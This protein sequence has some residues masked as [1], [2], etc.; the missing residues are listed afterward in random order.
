MAV[1]LQREAGDVCGPRS[2]LFRDAAARAAAWLAAHRWAVLTLN[3][4]VG[5]LY[6]PTL[7]YGFL[8]WDDP[9]YILDNP[10]IRS[11]HPA[12]LVRIIT[13]V[14][15]RN[16]AP[17]T[18]FSF[19]VDHTLWDAWAGGYHL[20]NFVLHGLNGVLLY[21]LI[22]RLSGSRSV[23]W[24]T[25]ALWAVHPVQVESVAWISSRKGVLSATFLLASSLCWLREERNERHEFQGMLWF[26]LALLTK[27]IAVVFPAVVLSYDL[28]VRRKPLSDALARQIIPGFLAL[29]LLVTTVGAQNAMLGGVREHLALSRAEIMAVDLVIL[30]EYVGMLLWPADLCVLYDPPTSGI[31]LAAFVAGLGWTAVGGSAWL[32]R[33]RF[34]FVT[35]GMV[36]WVVFLAPVL[37]FVPITTLMNDRYLYLPS[38]PLFA[39]AV[40]GLH[41]VVLRGAPISRSGASRRGESLPLPSGALVLLT[42]LIVVVGYSAAT[43]RYLPVWRDGTSLWEHANRHVPQLAVVQIQRANTLHELGETDQAIAV[44]EQALIRCSPDEIDRRRIEEKL[45]NWRAAQAESPEPVEAP[46]EA[47]EKSDG[48]SSSRRFDSART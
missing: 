43:A 36:T 4:L 2:R 14:V 38:I 48:F 11:W 34:P 25:A 24:L 3:A 35:L 9:W 5:I 45:A 39:L 29:W 19:L 20:T 18:I 15:A 22:L 12:N 6:A 32:L 31:M 17:V 27:A 42:G 21:A 33:Q 40:A 10:L 37:N 44:L 46:R 13:E 28:L 23:A 47:T 16:Y 26:M 7:A 30:W 41:A 8:N 1:G